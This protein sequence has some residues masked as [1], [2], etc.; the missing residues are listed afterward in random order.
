[1]RT[2]RRS[3]AFKRD[4]RRVLANSR[5]KDAAGLLQAVVDA[6]AADQP[7]PAANRD[8]AL[9]GDWMPYRE[10]HVRPDLLLIYRKPDADTLQLARLGSHS[11]LFG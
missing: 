10:C 6:L 5:Y 7:L 8:H 9:S 4:V 3:S 1:M 11:E 2:I